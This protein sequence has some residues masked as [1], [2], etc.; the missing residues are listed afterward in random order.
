MGIFAGQKPQM[1]TA[2]LCEA[3]Q[4]ISRLTQAA[5]SGSLKSLNTVLQL[6]FVSQTSVKLTAGFEY[7]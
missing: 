5:I 6:C 3:S 7:H 4:E 2:V 1:Q